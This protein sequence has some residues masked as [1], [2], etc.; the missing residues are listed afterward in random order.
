MYTQQTPLVCEFTHG[1]MIAA[2][3]LHCG[4]GPS[5]IYGHACI[6]VY[7]NTAE[8]ALP[9]CH[10]QYLFRYHSTTNVLC[11]FQFIELA[12]ALMS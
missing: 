7:S 3:L 4:T 5:V 11:T 2:T 1:R 9:T 8:A 6:S 12:L 10:M